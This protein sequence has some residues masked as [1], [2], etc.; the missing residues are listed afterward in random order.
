[1]PNTIFPLTSGVPRGAN[2]EAQ[3]YWVISWEDLF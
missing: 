3:K 1:M 2:E